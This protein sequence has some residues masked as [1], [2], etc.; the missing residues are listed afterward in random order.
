MNKIL[1]IVP[2]LLF[3]CASA[4][5]FKER[6]Q[7][8]QYPVCIK[9]NE[10]LDKLRGSPDKAN[11]KHSELFEDNALGIKLSDEYKFTKAYTRLCKTNDK[12]M[13]TVDPSEF[14]KWSKPKDG[15]T[16]INV[17]IYNSSQPPE[18]DTGI[19]SDDKFIAFN[20]SEL[21]ADL[22]SPINQLQVK[23]KTNEALSLEKTYHFNVSFEY[24]DLAGELKDDA[25]FK[26]ALDLARHIKFAVV[27]VIAY[28]EKAI[29]SNYLQYNMPM[30]LNKES[31]E[32][33]H[34]KTSIDNIKAIMPENVEVPENVEREETNYEQE[35]DKTFWQMEKVIFG[36]SESIYLCDKDKV[37]TSGIRDLAKSKDSRTFL[38]GVYLVGVT[39]L[40]VK[41]SEDKKSISID[42]D[43]DVPRLFKDFQFKKLSE[44]VE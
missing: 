33:E 31:K 29:F 8:D 22:M 26:R 35:P 40:D 44:M 13:Y 16:G 17:V 25:K 12:L 14:D 30:P 21:E 4:P 41:R 24:P 6:F 43:V 36:Y 39:K 34:L 7:P 5:K 27:S 15:Q 18:K 19:S 3:G 20:L 10:F 38:T 11:T 28:A 1:I 32:F 42:V 23:S 2:I 9:A 37:C